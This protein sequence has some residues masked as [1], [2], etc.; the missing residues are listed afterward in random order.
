MNRD[1]VAWFYFCRE[2]DDVPVGKTNAPV[3]CG[4]ANRT[5]VVGAVDTDA[6]LVERDPHYANRIT[7]SRR[8][9]MEI[10][11]PFPMLEHFLV[12]TESGHLGDAAYFPLANGRSR[13]RRAN[14]HRISSDELLSLKYSEHVGFGVDLD[15]D[16]RLCG[17]VFLRLVAVGAFILPF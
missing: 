12:V 4:A 8:K 10:T 6:F 14:R 11:A 17:F 16:R 15:A 2:T 3:A 5:R 7:R 13:L 9:Q 1:V